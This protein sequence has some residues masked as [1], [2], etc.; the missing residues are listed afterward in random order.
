MLSRCVRTTTRVSMGSFTS[1]CARLLP[2]GNTAWR[3]WIEKHL[4]QTGHFCLVVV[5]GAVVGVVVVL[6]VV[7]GVVVVVVVVVVVAVAAAVV[8]SFGRLGAAGLVGRRLRCRRRRRNRRHRRHRH[9]LRAR[10]TKRP[11]N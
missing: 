11:S 2:V 3:V 5:P 4:P 7:V 6:V 9:C 10:P 1:S 8:V